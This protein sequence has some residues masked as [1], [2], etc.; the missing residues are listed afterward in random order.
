M[1]TILLL[2]VLVGGCASQTLPSNADQASSDGPGTSTEPVCLIDCALAHSLGLDAPPAT[3]I[4]CVDLA[5]CQFDR[6]APTD[7]DPW[8]CL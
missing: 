1:R 8:V 2:S 6:C 5:K 7:S 4:P 3:K